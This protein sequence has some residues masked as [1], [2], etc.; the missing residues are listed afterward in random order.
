MWECVNVGMGECVNVGMCEGNSAD[1]SR[2]T[3]TPFLLSL[4]KI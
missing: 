1:P 3:I 2:W 4:R